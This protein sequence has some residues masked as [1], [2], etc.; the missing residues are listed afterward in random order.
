MKRSYWLVG[1]I[2]LSFLF[3][4][5]I[6]N[7][8]L[9]FGA[10]RS[11][12]RFLTELSG[13]RNPEAYTMTTKAYQEQ[14]SPQE[15]NRLARRWNLRDFSK[16]ESWEDQ[17][18][19]GQVTIST[20]VKTASGASVPLMMKLVKED[21]YWRVDD[22]RGPP[23]PG[24]RYNITRGFG[25]RRHSRLRDGAESGPKPSIPSPDEARALLKGSLLDLDR[26][27]QSGDYQ[28]FRNHVAVAWQDDTPAVAFDH[29]LASLDRDVLDLARNTEPVCG[30][31]IERGG[32]IELHGNYRSD[33]QVLDCRLNYMHEP[34][35]WKLASFWIGL[36]ELMPDEIPD[37]EPASGS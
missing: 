12:S 24:P 28:S 22:L 10:S 19:T 3:L 2:G 18:G 13:G 1:G 32:T 14:T 33:E 34:A 8:L 20:N 15:F 37:E 7:F 16:I 36:R 17:S 23:S 11:A 21:G 27:L 31:V 9:T 25:S 30:P 29:V 6:V 5:V 35:G 4:G 26:A